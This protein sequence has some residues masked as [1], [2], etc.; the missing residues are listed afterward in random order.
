MLQN[1]WRDHYQAAIREVNPALLLGRMREAE[2]AMLACVQTLTQ[3][4]ESCA[5][6]QAISEALARLR[7]LR[8][9]A[10]FHGN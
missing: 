9:N 3:D 7:T 5:E 1:N 8:I 10:L 6:R 2:N 4:S